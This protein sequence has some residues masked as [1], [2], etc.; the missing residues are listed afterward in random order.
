MSEQQASDRACL[1]HD[2]CWFLKVMKSLSLTE[3]YQFYRNYSNL[4]LALYS[5]SIF[6]LNS[7]LK[8][9]RMPGS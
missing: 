8:V 5:T 7:L 2:F 4:Y 9:T 6:L 1:V 3:T